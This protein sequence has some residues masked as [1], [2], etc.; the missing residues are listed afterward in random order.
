M[1]KF[2]SLVNK[3][4]AAIMTTTVLLFMTAAKQDIRQVHVIKRST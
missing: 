3:N 1:A 2:E 4:E